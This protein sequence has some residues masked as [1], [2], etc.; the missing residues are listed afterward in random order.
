MVRFFT[1]C[2]EHALALIDRFTPSLGVWARKYHRVFKYI[3]SGG[4]AA[5]VDL[6]VLYALTDFLGLHYL[7][8]ATFAFLVAFGVSFTLQKFWTFGDESMDRVHVQL[9]WYL[10][11][12]VANLFV[13][14]GLMYLFV[15][16]FGVWYFL[17]QIIV[18]VAMAC[19][20]FLLYRHIIFR[21]PQIY[22]DRNADIRG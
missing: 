9:A 14:A 15:D 8:S 10:S 2:E 4:T 16:I 18:G 1:F 17:A 6:G 19:Y 22:A 11:I 12:A 20:G 5:V 7:I 3:C 13:N 21:K